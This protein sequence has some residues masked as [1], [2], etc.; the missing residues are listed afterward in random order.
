MTEEATAKLSLPYLMPSQAQKHVIHNEA[1]RMLDAIVH[2]SVRDRDLST[3]PASPA[4]G[5]RYLVAASSSGDWTGESGKLAAFQD[6]AWAFL[7]AQTGWRIWVEDESLFLVFDG[8]AWRPAERGVNP[9]EAVGVN[10]TAEAGNRLAVAS[11]ASLFNHEGNGH[12]LKI[13]KNAASDT[14]SVLFQTG[15]GGRAEF[16]TAGDDDFHVKV[17]PDGAAWHEAIVIARDTGAVSFPNSAV[18]GGIAVEDEGSELAPGTARLNFA[19]A[20][21]SVTGAGTGKVTITVPGTGGSGNVPAGGSAGQVL[22]KQSAASLDTGWTTLLGASEAPSYANAGGQG[23]RSGLITVSASDGLVGGT[24][25]ASNLVDGATGSNGADSMAFVSGV[26]VAGHF[27]QFDF[28]IG[29]S[30][31]VTE[32]SWQQSAAHSHGIWRWQGSS[33]G[34]SWSAIGAPFALGGAAVQIHAELAS[35]TAGF[36][37]YRLLGV[38]GTASGSPF[39]REL[40]FK[41]GRTILDGIVDVPKG[42]TKGQVLAKL[43]DANGFCGWVDPAGTYPMHTDGILAEWHFREGAGSTARDLRKSSHIVFDAAFQSAWSAPAPQWTRR[44]LA[45]EN[46]MIQTP[47]L[48]GVRTVAFA[49]RVKRGETAGF[50]LSGGPTGSGGGMLAQSVPPAVAGHIGGG[51]GVAPLVR[52]SDNGGGALRLNR[53]GWVLVFCEFASA[54]NTALGF[55]GRHSNAA[56][57]C[58]EFEIGWAACWN[59]ALTDEERKTVYDRVR[60]IMADRGVFLDWRDCATT[61]DCVLLWGQSNADGRALIADLSTTD[62]ARR[63]MR[64]VLIAPGNGPSTRY[65]SPEYLALGENQQ[66]TNPLNHFGPET[67]AAWAHEDADATRLR[68]LVINKLALGSTFLASSASGAPAAQSWN[69]GELQSVGLLWTSLAHWWDTEQRL[70]AQGI[71]PRLKALWWMQGEQDATATAYSGSYGANLQALWDAVKLYSGYNAGMKAIVARI[72]DQDPAA[73]A[74]AKAELRAAQ[75][76]FVSANG[77]SAALIDTDAFALAP[78]NVHYNAAGMKA[79]GQAFYAATGL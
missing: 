7:A 35:N 63:A 8:E 59:D 79:L 26:A 75:S 76:A 28:G 27:I 19:G 50:L 57:R 67:G 77:P 74:T 23:D 71:G 41:L 70:L 48:T 2:L 18:A 21:V 11:A 46:G 54:S 4:E 6:G 55:G 34:T 72:R 61:A 1:I 47:V 25:L 49:Y 65:A 39:I 5:D 14:A 64:N 62:Q 37:F 10:T 22:V 40:E 73:N 32:A 66:Q 31:V 9:V 20:G 38:S 68:P 12:Q 69:A 3:P 60:A 43:S 17:S 44:G 51:T 29:A 36:R 30:R 15:F 78:D 42:G 56:S 58:A 52:R 16:G 53:G 24:T 33:D 13:N 45:L